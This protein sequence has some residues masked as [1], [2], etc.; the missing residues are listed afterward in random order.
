MRLA[1]EHLDVRGGVGR[2]GASSSV[3]GGAAITMERLSL[4]GSTSL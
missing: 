2:H 4:V 3:M 1:R